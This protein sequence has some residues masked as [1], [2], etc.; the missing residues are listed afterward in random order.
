MTKLLSVRAK[1]ETADAIERRSGALGPKHRFAA[2]ADLPG[3]VRMGIPTGD[4][5]MV[6]RV[7]A[8]KVDRGNFGIYLRNGRHP[9]SCEFPPPPRS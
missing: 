2:S 4:Q 6:R 7:V 1:P 8:E 5:A 3:S 9:I